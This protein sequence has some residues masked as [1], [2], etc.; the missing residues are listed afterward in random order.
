MKEDVVGTGWACSRR[1]E[2]ALSICTAHVFAASPVHAA[3]AGGNLSLRAG[4]SAF[5]RVK[6]LFSWVF[7]VEN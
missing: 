2:H 6:V 4:S 1:V 3:Q 7:R 5:S